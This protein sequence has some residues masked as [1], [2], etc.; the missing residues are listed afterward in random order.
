MFQP[1]VCLRLYVNLLK[2]GT[3]RI[4]NITQHE[5]QRASAGRHHQIYNTIEPI[6]QNSRNTFTSF[7]EITI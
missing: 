5:N 2:Y 4:K 7:Q 1:S 3:E 6:T